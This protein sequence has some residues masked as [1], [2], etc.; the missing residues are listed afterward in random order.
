VKVIEC[1]TAWK[2]ILA[3][4]E[5]VKAGVDIDDEGQ[6]LK[7]WGITANTVMKILSNDYTDRKL[8]YA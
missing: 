6:S 8:V 7:C 1:G 5:Q 2:S 3:R 4:M